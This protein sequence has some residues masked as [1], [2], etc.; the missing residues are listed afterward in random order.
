[1]SILPGNGG[2]K[3]PGKVTGVNVVPVFVVF[4]VQFFIFFSPFITGASLIRYSEELEPKNITFSFGSSNLTS[5]N[6]EFHG[7]W[8]PMN[9]SSTRFSDPFVYP[10]SFTFE[11]EKSG[12]NGLSGWNTSQGFENPSVVDIKANHSKIITLENSSI[13]RN[14]NISF[15]GGRSEVI[16]FWMMFDRSFDGIFFSL[17]N[18]TGSF[19]SIYCRKLNS[20]ISLELLK[21]AYIPE[22]IGERKINCWFLLSIY[23]KNSSVKFYI[24]GSGYLET[25][26]EPFNS[27]KKINFSNSSISIDAI[28]LSWDENYKVGS[29]KKPLREFSIQSAIFYP[30]FTSID[31][32]MVEMSLSMHLSAGN[33]S[34]MFDWIFIST[35][36]DSIQLNSISCNSSIGNQSL[37]YKVIQQKDLIA[38]EGITLMIISYSDLP[39]SFMLDDVKVTLTVDF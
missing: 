18:S 37:Y 33:L 35:E 11:I 15:E 2:K 26:L 36:N 13:E 7:N 1:M 34:K 21:N 24:D 19:L 17:E 39:E 28:G 29:N 25:S 38:H 22:P 10:G 4:I 20:S 5:N 9:I 8:I 6:Q 31:F 23:L 27:L 3:K 32:E 30:I 14:L 12:K 16:E